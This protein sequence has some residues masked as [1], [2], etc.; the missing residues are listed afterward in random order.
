[1]AAF[2]DMQMVKRRFFA[3]RNGVIADMLRRAG[4]PYRII[5]G[6]NL[7]QIAEIAADCGRNASLARRLW[8]NSTTRCSRLMAPMLMDAA[9][10]SRDEVIKMALE[11]AD[12]ETADIFCHRF[13]RHYPDAPSIAVEIYA[14]A[15]SCSQT[16]NTSVYSQSS[17]VSISDDSKKLQAK[18]NPAAGQA[19]RYTALRLMANLLNLNPL[20]YKSVATQLARR[21]LSLHPSDSLPLARTILSDAEY[22]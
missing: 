9:D 18:P 15:E 1:M 4:S 7:P 17:D 11:I 16:A 20:Q 10:F 6:L 19:R 12:S 21:E 22:L 13:L 14:S 3:M 5:F 2:N 8:A